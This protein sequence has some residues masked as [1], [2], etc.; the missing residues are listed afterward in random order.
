[1]T[2]EEVV[3]WLESLKKEV[4]KAENRTLWHYAE[5]IDVA[6]KTLSAEAVQL[7]QT[8]TLDALRYLAQNTDE[9]RKEL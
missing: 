8:D 9:K 3:K 1:M 7:K 4:G 5:S 6:I 2:R